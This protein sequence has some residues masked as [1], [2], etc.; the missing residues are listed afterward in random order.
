MSTARTVSTARIVLYQAL[1]V[2][3]LLLLLEACARIVHTVQ[4][5]RSKA[6]DWYVY[7]HDLGWE[8]RASFAGP[9]DCG[10]ERTFDSQ[11]LF[12]AEAERLQEAA[13]G[14][15]RVVFVGDSNTYGSCRETDETFVG[16]VNRLLPHVA[17]VN[18]GVNG[19]TSYQ[20]YKAL[21]KY[22]DPIKPDL[23]FISFNFNDR[24]F[25][26]EPDMAD[27]PWA[28]QRLYSANLIQGLS[29]VSYLFRT[30][31]WVSRMLAPAAGASRIGEPARV[32]NIKLERVRP[33]VSP[34]DYRENLKRMVQWAKQRGAGVV[35]IALGDN[36]KQTAVLRE[37]VKLLSE[38]KLEA[39]IE[40]FIVVTEHPDDYWFSA[41]A[42]LYLSKAYERKGEHDEAKEALVMDDAFSGIT[43]GYPMVL[44]TEYLAIMRE[45]AAEQ[46]V[47]VVD[48]ASELNKVPEV[49]WDFCHFNERGHE[50]V[51]RLVADAIEAARARRAA[52]KG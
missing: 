3:A 13:E 49:F 44:D 22:G 35:F 11:G 51:G 27:G 32:A 10:I 38:G 5:D 12:A 16:V 37:G 8:R 6:P 15:L 24:R 47:A 2:V 41:L 33:R 1:I 34:Q 26:L 21:L 9:D 18:L 46:G 39:A 45:V 36:P 20:G 29:D 52:G 50:I 25:V 43:G 4:L 23:V 7:S 42:H 48:A 40:R 17:A 28:F 30:A 19:Y 31:I 14:R